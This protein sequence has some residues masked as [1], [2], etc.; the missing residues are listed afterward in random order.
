MAIAITK[1]FETTCRLGGH[2]AL[3]HL[4]PSEYEFHVGAVKVCILF[5]CVVC[6]FATS[7]DDRVGSGLIILAM[8]GSGGINGNV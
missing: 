5:P 2:V 1:P 7:I 4:N 3:T 8:G 6:T